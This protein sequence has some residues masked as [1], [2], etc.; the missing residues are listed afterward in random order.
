M[1]SLAVN[2]TLTTTF[3]SNG[4]LETLDETRNRFLS[5]LE[6]SKAALE[7]AHADSAEKVDALQSTISGRS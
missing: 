6:A 2:L 7:K 3:A 5:Q 4:N 1:V